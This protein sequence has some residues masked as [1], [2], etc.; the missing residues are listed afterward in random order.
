MHGASDIVTMM[1]NDYKETIED[2]SNIY[3]ITNDK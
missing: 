1:N 2:A 3:Q